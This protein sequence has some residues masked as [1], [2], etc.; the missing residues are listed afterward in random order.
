MNGTSEVPLDAHLTL[1]FSDALAV[2]TITPQTLALSGPDGPVSTRVIAAE[3]GRLAFVWPIKP[4]AEGT[5]YVLRVSGPTNAA[6]VPLVPSSITFTTVEAATGTS[7]VD[8]SEEWVPDAE[9]IKLGWR[10]GRPASTWESLAPL[11][12]P[13]GVTAISGR[14]LTLD[15]RPLRGVTLAIEGDGST[16]SD[17]TGRF[18]LTMKAAVNGRR[19]LQIEGETASSPGRSYGFFEYGMTVIGAQTNVLPFTIWMP[20]LDTAHAVTIPSP[21]T[22]EVVVTT[23]KIPGLELHIPPATVIVGEDGKPVTRVSITPIPV[24]RPPFPLAKN[25]IVPVYFTVQPGGAYVRTGG[26]GPKGAQLVYPNYRHDPAGQRLQFY[27]YDPDVK[28]WY[29][30]GMGTVAPDGG[31]V[32]PDPATRL[33]AFTG[34]MINDGTPTPG[35]GKPPGA[36]TRADP[37]DPATGIFVMSKTDLYLPDVI[38]LA[39]TRTYNS[40]DGYARPA[41]RSM[42][43]QYAMFLH[44]ELQYQQVDLILPE[45]GKVHYVRTST[46]TSF[47]DAVF[48]HQETATTSATPTPFYKSIISWNGN[49]W[50]LTL[51]DGTVYVFGDVAPLQAIRDR[52]GNTVTVTHANGQTGNITQVT[53]PNGRWISFTYDGSNRITQAKDNIGRI[54]AYTYDTN[55]NLSTVT[56]PENGVTTYTYD[57]SNR[58]AT[59]KD[60]R[61]VVYLTNLYQNGRVAT[62]ILADPSAVYTFAYTVDG[63]GNVTQTDITDALGHVERLTFNADHYILT[64]IEAYGTS[65]ERTTT[66]ERQTGSNLVTAVTDGLSRRT[67][68]TYD[69]SGHVL[70]TTRLAGTA[71]AVTTTFTYEASFGQLATVT[72]PSNHT[73]TMAYDSLGRVTSATDSLSHQTTL[74]WNAQGQLTSVTDALQH[75]WQFAYTGPD[76]TSV[77]DPLSAVQRRFFDGA[78]RAL[79]VTDPLGRQTRLVSDKLNRVTA[80]TDPLGGQTSLAYDPNGNLLTLTDALTHATTYAYDANDQVATRTDALQKMASYQ[81]DKVNHLTQETDRKGQV[82]SYE[83]D[84]LNRLTRITFADTSTIDYT[85]D[86]GD[87]LTEIDD[88]ANGTITRDYDGL[89]RLTSEISSNGTISYTYEDDG[90][91]ASSTVTGQS[92]VTYAYDDAHRLTS[93]TQGTSVVSLT[94]D[95]ANRR[96]TLTFPNGI[97]ATY[98]YDAANQLTSL[99]Y[100]LSGNPVGDLTY[101]YDA[102]GHRTS[103]GGSFARTGLPQA[104]ASAASYDAGNRVTTWGGQTFS[105]DANGNLGSD[106]LTSYGWNP[107]DQLTSLSGAA[108][109]TFQYDGVRRRKGKT[110][111]GTTTNFLHDGPNLVQELTSGGTPTANLLTGLGIDEA[112][113]R[114]DSSGTSTLLTDSLGSTIALTN[115]SGSV[116]TSYTFEPFGA[117]TTSG[118]TSTNAGQFT[119]RDNDATGLYYYRARFYSPGA[120]RFI[121]ED[122]LGSAGGLNL[123]AYAANTP[124]MYVDPFG[125]KPGAGFGGNG[126]GDGS[127]GGSGDGDGAGSGSGAGAGSGSGNGS[128]GNGSGSGANGSGHCGPWCQV[129]RDVTRRAG[130]MTRVKTY[131]QIAGIS[132]AG[133][134]VGVAAV[135]VVGGAGATVAAETAGESTIQGFTRHGINQVINR[136][137]RPQQILEAVKSPVQV[138][139]PM[140]DQLGRVSTQYIGPNATVVVNPTGLVITAW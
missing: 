90:R 32:K 63:S 3:S 103:V 1:R 139:G 136:G 111:A 132:I 114:A 59:I 16:R 124:T 67:E 64:D 10:T 80:V 31:Q 128:G 83:Y 117:T 100:T 28:D 66:I 8:D 5:T 49:G 72:D 76:L 57:G 121:S 35:N 4:L 84:A 130:P 92:S 125:L 86:L 25:V 75:S 110:V 62:Q 71:D 77:T 30:Y 2:H 53:S 43:H 88:S 118:S 87:R 65:L 116:Q 46:G 14:V 69:S 94:Y 56:D 60:G 70:T 18:L 73:W 6:D 98:G 9:S 37:V 33:Y 126:G 11:M 29:V 96:S 120:Q 61:G 38:P 27:H 44:S 113:T 107:R 89:D 15:G 58:M 106:G 7:N 34:A 104:L 52:F 51:K 42:T 115:T 140:V 82:T 20:K 108:S 133:A 21:T 78:G 95:N 93:I 23:P 99:A 17:R 39:L 45:G 122:P 138:R 12:A 19:V 105:H 26:T 74:A 129:A 91:R 50:D 40:G 123:F 81:Y 68:F 85:Y 47:A 55:G 102:G 13:T 36:P 127:G 101:T 112:F 137:I 97:V 48:V 131:A 41:G 22:K 24:D 134:A 109:A 119:G 135:E 54:V 79:A